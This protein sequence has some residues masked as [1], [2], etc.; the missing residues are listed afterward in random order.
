MKVT[1][2]GHACM[3]VETKGKKLLFDPFLTYNELFDTATLPHLS[4]DQIQA[5]YILLSHGHDL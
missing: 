4:A 3:L 1:Y 5:D 2:C